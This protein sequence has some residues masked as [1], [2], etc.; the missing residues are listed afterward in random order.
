MADGLD[1]K[2]TILLEKH[3]ELKAERVTT[4]SVIF[5][6]ETHLHSCLYIPVLLINESCT[7]WLGRKELIRGSSRIQDLK[8]VAASAGHPRIAARL[9]REWHSI[10]DLL[11]H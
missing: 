9:P 1:R 2:L 8:S 11:F 10:Q 3:R 4:L 5:S 6:A 7:N